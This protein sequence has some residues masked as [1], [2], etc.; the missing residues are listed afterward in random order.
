MMMMILMV[1]IANS[2]RRN[3]SVHIHWESPLSWSGLLLAAEKDA[4]NAIGDDDY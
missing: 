3:L 1:M 2:S 4:D